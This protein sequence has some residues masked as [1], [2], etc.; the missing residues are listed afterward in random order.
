MK[1]TQDQFDCIDSGLEV[2]VDG[3]PATL[4]KNGD[5]VDEGRHQYHEIIF[6]CDDK[7]YS[8]TEERSGSYFTDWYYCWEDEK[9]V[10]CTE[11]KP[12]EV[13]VIEWQE[14]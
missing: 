13:I 12:V 9:Y 8:A 6:K 14:V 2:C 4:V 11:V 10:D 5:W 1:I 7:F 3:K